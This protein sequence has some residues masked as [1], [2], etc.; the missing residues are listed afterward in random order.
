MFII[1]SVLF[2]FWHVLV[3]SH[4]FAMYNQFI[5]VVFFVCFKSWNSL[6]KSTSLCNERWRGRLE[7]SI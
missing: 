6:H 7:A 2:L 4:G 1:A 5:K 3:I